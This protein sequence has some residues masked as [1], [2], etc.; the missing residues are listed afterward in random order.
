[1]VKKRHH[2]VPESYLKHFCDEYGFVHVIR[3]D[4]PHKAFRQKP[5]GFAF[6]KYY[7]AQPLPDGGRDT[8]KLENLFSSLEAKWPPI[9]GRLSREEN[10]NNELETIFQFVALQR[11]R[12]PAM[13]DA[14]EILE[15][16]RVR[17]TVKAMAAAGKLPRLP[18]GFPDLLEDL[19]VSI[20]P[21]RSILAMPKLIEGMGLVMH[22]VGLSV[23]HNTTNIPFLTSDNPVVYFDPTTPP[24]VMRPYKLNPLGGEVVM[25]MPL[26]PSMMLYGHS[27]NKQ[28][29]AKFGL[30]HGKIADKEM[31]FTMNEQICRFAYEGVFAPQ[32]GFEFMV[33]PFAAKSPTVRLSPARVNYRVAEVAQFEFGPRTTKPKWKAI[34][35]PSE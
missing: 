4:T 26:T 21:H 23:L 29:F 17:S 9:I 32:S 14:I 19:T 5:D 34:S 30:T 18:K 24:E 13:R 35:D 33:Q 22:R 10:V 16:A 8:E 27:I 25:M 15:A 1:M 2:F 12:V 6:H 11:A 7:Y 3:K 28:S 20:D 31:V